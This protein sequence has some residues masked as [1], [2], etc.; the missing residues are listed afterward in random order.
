MSNIRFVLVKAEF[1]C[2]DCGKPF[3]ALCSAPFDTT[4]G[5]IGPRAE[6]EDHRKVCNDCLHATDRAREARSIRKGQQKAW[7][8]GEKPRL[9]G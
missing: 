2:T 3:L 9:V 7:A 6:M 8:K 1:G 5:K 4:T